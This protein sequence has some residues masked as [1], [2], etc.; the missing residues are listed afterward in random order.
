MGPSET[1]ELH[2]WAEDGLPGATGDA[3]EL[4]YGNIVLSEGEP[5]TLNPPGIGEVDVNIYYNKGAFWLHFT[6][7][8]ESNEQEKALQDLIIK[9][10]DGE[11]IIDHALL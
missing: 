3:T 8:Y 7:E 11:D 9:F 5:F 4:T 10:A 2:P 6:C 1:V